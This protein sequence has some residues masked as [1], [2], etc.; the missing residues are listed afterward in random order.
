VFED[1][2]TSFVSGSAPGTASP[3][4]SAQS[5][6]FEDEPTNFFDADK[7]QSAG[8]ELEPEEATAFFDAANHAQSAEAALQTATSGAAAS[9]EDGAD[10][11]GYSAEKTEF[12][13]GDVLS[14]MMLDDKAAAA[15]LPSAGGFGDEEATEIFFNKDDGVG[16]AELMADDDANMGPGAAP[17]AF[18][19]RMSAPIISPQLLEPAQGMAAAPPPTAAPAAAKS[20]AGRPRAATP[21]PGKMG[22]RARSRTVEMRAQPRA[23]PL[24][25]VLLVI[26]V[27]TL[28]LAVAGLMI[29]TPLGITLGLRA[30][31]TGSM[32]VRSAPVTDAIV[33]LDGV[34]RGKAP[35]RMDG[36]RAGTRL[37][38]LEATGY[39]KMSREVQLGGGTTTMLDVVMTPLPATA[40][41]KP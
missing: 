37:L 18:V 3:R 16:I 39:E 1:E 40:P 38:E 23:D 22:A 7:L 29:K 35:L 30:A 12:L 36:V 5:A 9:G 6:V 26:G 32:E 2:P 24:S 31:D 19:P 8:A 20:A 28:T 15:P 4:A 27:V 14:S 17:A 11:M 33:T 13:G 25:T 10:D 34:V 41:A 21:V